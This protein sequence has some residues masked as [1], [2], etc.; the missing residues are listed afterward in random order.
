M[1]ARK[2]DDE[3]GE[4][5]HDDVVE[6]CE[7]PLEKGD[8]LLHRKQRLLVERV[9]DDADDD[10]VEDPGCAAD[11]VDVPVRDGVVASWAD[12]RDHLE[13]TVMRAEP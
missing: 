5:V 4:D 13:K 6:L 3:L 7:R 10:S 12:G 11:D 2:V 1:L 9:T 8:P